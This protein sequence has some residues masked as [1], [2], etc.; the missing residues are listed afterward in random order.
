M[1]IPSIAYI[2]ASSGNEH[3]SRIREGHHNSKYCHRLSISDFDK[4]QNRD[5]PYNK[6]LQCL[7]LILFLSSRYTFQY[8]LAPSYFLLA[9][10]VPVAP[11]APAL[12]APFEEA[13]AAYDRRDFASGCI[14]CCRLLTR[15]TLTRKP[16]SAPC[17]IVA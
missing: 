11:S 3:D 13:A 17:T 14:S 4:G 15:A 5:W 16:I 2:C 8:Y 12:A 10:V 6:V 7:S 9:L 1:S